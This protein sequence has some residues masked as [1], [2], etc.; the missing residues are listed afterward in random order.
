MKKIDERTVNTKKIF[1]K[2][3]PITVPLYAFNIPPQPT[4]C[5]AL[6]VIWECFFA[7]TPCRE[8]TYISRLLA[9]IFIHK[10]E[11]IIFI[12]NFIIKINKV[13]HFH[14]MFFYAKNI[15]SEGLGVQKKALIWEG[16]FVPLIHRQ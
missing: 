7:F 5:S 14:R 2:T 15:V 6:L 3:A 11:P 8:N 12:T 1:Q 16:F 4:Q 10:T 13:V 9:I